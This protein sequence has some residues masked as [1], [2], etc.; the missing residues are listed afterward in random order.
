M[1]WGILALHGEKERFFAQMSGLFDFGNL[2]ILGGLWLA[3]KVFHECWHGFVCR[4]LGGVVPEAGVALLLFTT[5]LGYVN[6]SSSTA[7]ASRWHHNR[8]T[9]TTLVTTQRCA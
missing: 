5:P 1:I 2:W 9:R 8:A 4:R 7:F 3:L 6:A